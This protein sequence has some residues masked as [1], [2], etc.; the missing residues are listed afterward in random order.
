MLM[1]VLKKIWKFIKMSLSGC[2]TETPFNGDKEGVRNV[3]KS[4]S[5]KDKN[6]D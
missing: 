3:E 6:G 2:L 1:L 4:E 5:N